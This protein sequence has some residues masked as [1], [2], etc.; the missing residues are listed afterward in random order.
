MVIL[1]FVDVNYPEIQ[2]PQINH[3]NNRVKKKIWSTDGQQGGSG[4]DKIKILKRWCKVYN[5]KYI[6][7]EGNR[8]TIKQAQKLEKKN[9]NASRLVPTVLNLQRFVGRRRIQTRVV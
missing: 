3:P 7:Y 6:I 4:K 1:L 8:L 9:S 2:L 5:G